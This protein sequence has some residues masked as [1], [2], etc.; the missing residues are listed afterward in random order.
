M[1][2]SLRELYGLRLSDEGLAT[3]LSDGTG[4]S[5]LE[6][7]FQVAASLP[8]KAIGVPA[9]PEAGI[10]HTKRL[11]GFTCLQ[12]S[13]ARNM[14]APMMKQD[15]S[16]FPRMLGVVLT[17]GFQKCQAIE[18]EPCPQLQYVVYLFLSPHTHSHTLECKHMYFVALHF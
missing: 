6:A 13:S 14:S 17:D 12:V 2:A 9:L 1:L 11:A 16:A 5:D 18:I 3:V 10:K 8:L 4:P 7:I 15:S